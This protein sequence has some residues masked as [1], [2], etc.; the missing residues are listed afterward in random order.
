M[1]NTQTGGGK[2]ANKLKKFH[3][4]NQLIYYYYYYLNYNK[5][6]VFPDAPNSKTKIFSRLFLNRIFPPRAHWRPRKRIKQ[7]KTDEK[8]KMI[9]QR[10]GEK[11]KEI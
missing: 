3:Q 6:F 9:N 11:I 2:S 8:K 10:V 7:I 4:F 1:K 5:F